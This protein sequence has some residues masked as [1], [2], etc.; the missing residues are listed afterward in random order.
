MKTKNRKIKKFFILVCTILSLVLMSCGK[1]Q[2]YHWEEIEYTE[3]NNLLDQKD[4]FYSIF[5]REDCPYCIDFIKY[6]QEI[7]K[8]KN[9]L[10]Y[11]IDTSSMT[12]KQ[13]LECIAEYDL[14]YVPAA[15]Y[16][17]KGIMMNSLI[18][19]SSEAETQSFIEKQQQS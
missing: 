8:E 11:V 2:E 3:F 9:L 1:I 13:K 15:Y 16:F 18:G 7:A 19:E 14:K 17:D 12:N 10:V 6:F 5:K 4:S